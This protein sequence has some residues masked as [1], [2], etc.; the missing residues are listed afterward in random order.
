MLDSE[1]RSCQGFR[2]MLQGVMGE[3]N[4]GWDWA[5]QCMHRDCIEKKLHLGKYCV[6]EANGEGYSGWWKMR[7]EV[8]WELGYGRPVH[9]GQPVTGPK[10]GRRKHYA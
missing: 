10:V 8:W 9:G 1:T 3:V 2:A 4:G 7:V 5:G 6:V